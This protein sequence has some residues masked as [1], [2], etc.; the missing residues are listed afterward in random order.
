MGVLVTTFSYK[1]NNLDYVSF[2]KNNNLG[3]IYF[4]K[5]SPT[6]ADIFLN[7][8]H[9]FDQSSIENDNSYQTLHFNVLALYTPNFILISAS[10]NAF[11][12]F[13]QNLF[14]LKYKTI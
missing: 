8:T 10:P 4:Y 13:I 6:T 2:Y 3:H 9:E 14:Q 12:Y 7:G 1:N 11:K 5:N